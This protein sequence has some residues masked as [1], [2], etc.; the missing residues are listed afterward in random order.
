[1]TDKYKVQTKTIYEVNKPRGDI[2][3]GKRK[4]IMISETRG[5]LLNGIKVNKF[6]GNTWFYER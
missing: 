6:K 1:M 5:T 4:V 3:I 2:F